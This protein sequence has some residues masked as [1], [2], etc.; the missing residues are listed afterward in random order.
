M[1]VRLLL[2]RPA[3]RGAA[4]FEDC[5][6]RGWQVVWWPLQTIVPLPFS[7]PPE[8]PLPAV[9]IVVSA[10]AAELALP[11]LPTS[12]RDTT[13]IAVGKAT[14][15]TLAELGWPQALVPSAENSENLLQLPPL[16][17][18]RGQ[19]MVLLRGEQGREL[20]SEQLLA[21]GA[22]LESLI[23]YRSEGPTSNAADAIRLWS[24]Q[25]GYIVVSST[26]AL[27]QLDQIVA[28]NHRDHLH[29]LC[30]GPRIN[31]AAQLL[32]KQVST[33]SALTANAI[34]DAIKQ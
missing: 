23:L 30:L 20:I 13:V 8:L 24:Q 31:A 10:H 32:F 34:N 29:L 9:V 4:L 27:Q 17:Q 14:A 22:Q 16:Q 12:W 6:T 11:N 25:P 28:K 1:A 33:L 18:V 15:Q 3:G 21:Q 5:S 2:T 19:R 26:Q 7:V